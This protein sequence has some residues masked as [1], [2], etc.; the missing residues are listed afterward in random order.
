MG[1]GQETE[2]HSEEDETTES[3]GSPGSR[4]GTGGEGE[5]PDAA[6]LVLSARARRVPA[7]GEEGRMVGTVPAS[8]A[9]G[10]GPVE[11]VELVPM[12]CVR[13]RIASFPV[14]KN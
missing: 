9:D 12:G 10:E 3:T 5:G 6:P 13:L 4:E 7:W 2:K 14:V 11:E 1:S 8:P